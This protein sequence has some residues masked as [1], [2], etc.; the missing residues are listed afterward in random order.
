MKGKWAVLGLVALGTFMTTLDASIVNISLPSIARTFHTP[1]GGAVEWVII[2]YLVVI[3]ATLLTFGR[4]SDL[5][6]RKPVWMAGLAVF[7]LGSICCGAAGSLP[8]LV[9]AR[10]FQGLGGALIFAPSFAIITDA[11]APSDRGRA[12]GL[13]AVVFAVGTSLGPTL[14]GLITEH[15]TWRWIFYLNVPLGALGLLAA[16]RVL[17][18]SE[19]RTR[20]PLDLLGSVLIAV[21]LSLLT[22][23]LSFG[24]EWGWASGRLLT[25]LAIA[26]VALVA[27]VPVEQ[28]ARRPIV[29]LALLRQPVLASSLGSM[30]LAMLALFAVSFVLPFYFEELRGFSVASAGLLLTPLPLTIAVVAPFS[31]ALADRIGSRWLAAGGLALASVGLLLLTRL[32]ADSTIDQIVGCLVLTGLGQGMFQSPNTRAF[33]NAAPAG[34]QGEASCLLATARVVGQTLSVALSAAIFTG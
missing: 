28:R 4:L 7:T 27:V 13:N 10:A 24:Q 19:A 2:A 3:A 32:N 1:I 12:L 34:Q 5:V 6:G 14:G 16:H 23:T 29:D 33:M 25:C 30:M 17:A 9:V 15:L 18:A 22:V 8:Q 31:G 21:G 20:Q 26:I 11:F